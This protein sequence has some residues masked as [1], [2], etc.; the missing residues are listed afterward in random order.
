MKIHKTYQQGQIIQL[1]PEWTE[2]G[3]ENIP[4]EVVEDRGSRVLVR[5]KNG[6]HIEPTS[7]IQKDWIL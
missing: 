1:K 6:L 4:I 2:K 3:E 7:T 5:W